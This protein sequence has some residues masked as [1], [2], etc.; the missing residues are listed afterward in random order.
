MKRFY[1]IQRGN[2]KNE[3]KSL[4]GSDGVVNL[5]YMGATEF[6][7]GAIPKAYRRMMYQFTEYEVFN[8]GIYTPE[9]EEL[10]VFCRKDC[11]AEVIQAIRHFIEHPYGLKEYSDLEKVPRATKIDRSYSRR[12]CNF[13]WCI[14]IDESYGDWMAFLQPQSTLFTESVKNDYENWWLKK[15][16]EEREEEYEKS[17]NW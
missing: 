4:T 6:E 1:L 3:G 2:F 5:D 14:D 12:C 11:S 13:W 7:W 10:M 9:H 15:S 8:T 17:L 16:I